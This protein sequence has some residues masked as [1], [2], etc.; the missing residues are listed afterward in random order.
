MFDRL[1]P[2]VWIGRRFQHLC[3]Q[4]NVRYKA[5]QLRTSSRRYRLCSVKVSRPLFSPSI[6]RYKLHTVLNPPRSQIA[7]FQTPSSP[8]Y[9][10]SSTL[11]M[12]ERRKPSTSFSNVFA[13]EWFWI[14]LDEFS[15]LISDRRYDNLMLNQLSQISVLW[16]NGEFDMQTARNIALD[17]LIGLYFLAYAS[18]SISCMEV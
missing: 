2:N 18:S 14:L 8:R 9:S 17:V 5:V 6:Y 4:L 11:S 13:F 1:V 12:V 3:Q 7:V 10:H 15:F 16:N